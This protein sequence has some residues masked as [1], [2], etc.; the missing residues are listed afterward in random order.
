MPPQCEKVGKDVPPS[1]Q[2]YCEI[3]LDLAEQYFRS[4]ELVT[5]QEPLINE[6]QD[7]LRRG[8]SCQLRLALL[9]K[10]VVSRENLCITKILH[11]YEVL[12]KKRSKVGMTKQE[13]QIVGDL[14][15]EYTQAVKE[16]QL[17][18]VR[19]DVD[20]YD[21]SLLFDI[22][23][24]GN[25]LHADYS[26]WQ[27]SQQFIQA[28]ILVEVEEMVGKLEKVLERVYALVRGDEEPLA[29]LLTKHALS[30]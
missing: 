7:R 3:F 14:R 24:N 29:D 9:R 4:A 25:V 2:A 22:V 18:M 13:R 17:A 5:A 30:R 27:K 15:E 10:F 28:V 16:H 21:S 23:L 1:S 12:A 11:H 26:K 6:H 19:T 8:A 20:R